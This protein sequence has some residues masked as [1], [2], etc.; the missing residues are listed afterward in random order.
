M[1]FLTYTHTHTHSLTVSHHA[2]DSE[3]NLTVKARWIAVDSQQET[4]NCWLFLFWV[5]FYGALQSGRE[6]RMDQHVWYTGKLERKVIDSQWISTCD[7]ALKDT[8]NAFQE[9]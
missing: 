6:G 1:H 2:S 5:F 7:I 4:S 8:L 9:R 3:G